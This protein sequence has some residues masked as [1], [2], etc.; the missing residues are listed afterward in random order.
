MRL[1]TFIL[2]DRLKKSNYNFLISDSFL[3]VGFIHI[4]GIPLTSHEQM[5]ILSYSL[6]IQCSI[7]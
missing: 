3:A 6:S 1:T 4:R 5:I 2:I 7:N